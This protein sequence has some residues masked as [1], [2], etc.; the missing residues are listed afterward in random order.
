[1][2][3][4]ERLLTALDRKVPDRLPVT[5]HHIMEYFL[6]TYMD[7][8]N[9]KQ[10]FEHFQMDAIHW[11]NPV[12]EEPHPNWEIRS[13][14]VENPDYPTT[15]YTIHTPGGELTT[16]IH[17]NEHTQ[18][19][20]E[21]FIKEKKD[22]EIL[23]EYLPHPKCDINAVNEQA[24][25]MGD[26]GII[27]GFIVCFDLTGQPGCWQDAACLV[28]IEK[29]IMSTFDDPG[30]VRQL[31]EILLERKK[32]FVKSLKGARYDVLELGGGDASTTVISPD[33]FNEYVAPYDAQLVALA[34]EAGQKIAYHTCGGMMP[35]LENI[36]DMGVDA[37]ETLTPP[38]MGGDTDLAEAKRRVGERVCL[39]GG[40]DQ[41]HYFSDCSEQETRD[42]VRKCFDQAGAGGGYIL[43]PSDHFFDAEPK[44]I[45]AFADEARRCT[46][47]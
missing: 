41:G 34:H 8:M 27:R 46:Y 26:R 20:S 22:I 47:E 40:F 12:L 9:N 33:V 11:T 3:S 15:R 25:Q 17:R 44:L 6:K 43:C 18:W 1:M 37:M 19:W 23:G 38:D 29:L 21:H 16:L 39:I 30:W 42:Y 4:R 2:T 10:F 45:A 24:D 31:L 14:E 5:T 32:T 36:A 7:G 13:E 28:G 35:I